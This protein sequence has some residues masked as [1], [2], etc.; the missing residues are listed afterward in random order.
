MASIAILA[1]R[2]SPDRPGGIVENT[3]EAFTR[4]RQLGADGV[5]LDVRL[6]SDGGLAVHH[7]PVVPGAGPVAELKVADLPAWVPLLPAALE[8]CAG[9]SVNIEIKN[10]PGEPGFDPGD[11]VARD[12]VELV[13]VAGRVPDVVVSSFWPDTL[14]VVRSVHPDL[15]TGLLLTSW[16][17][18]AAGLALALDQGCTALHPH[19]DLVDPGLVAEAH[20]AGLSVATWTVNDPSQLEGAAAAG[21]DTVITDHVV[22][23]VR[24]LRPE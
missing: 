17:D 19:V 6:T 14:G 20:G 3:L 12:V 23:A 24:A 21:V 16:F 10:L 9:L 22:Q 8:A 2:G 11:R 7:D 1:H 5:E 18:P 4:A 13:V 15:A